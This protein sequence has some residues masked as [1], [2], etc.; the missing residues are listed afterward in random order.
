MKKTLAMVLAV[1]MTLSLCA[2]SS[3][4]EPAKDGKDSGSGGIRIV[5]NRSDPEEYDYPEEDPQGEPSEEEPDLNGTMSPDMYGYFEFYGIYPNA[6]LGNRI[7]WK[8]GGSYAQKGGKGY[9]ITDPDVQVDVTGFSE[10][11]GYGFGHMD[12]TVKFY[13]PNDLPSDFKTATASNYYELYDTFTGKP[14]S[15]NNNQVDNHD[16]LSCES[17]IARPEGTFSVT[18]NQVS[19]STPHTDG[20]LLISELNYTIIF[21]TGYHGLDLVFFKAAKN[22][23]SWKAYSES[24]ISRDELLEEPNLPTDEFLVFEL[25]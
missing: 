1:I 13:Y 25:F 19:T 10:D 22:R 7:K 16:Q 5:D 21:Q 4:D 15:P 20:Y 9:Y 23:K 24:G 8:E 12:V 2:C 3:S 18:V 14:V 11:D 6:E 17:L